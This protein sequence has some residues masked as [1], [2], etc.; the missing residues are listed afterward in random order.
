MAR[1]RVIIDEGEEAVR[2]YDEKYRCMIDLTQDDD[3]D[4]LSLSVQQ[5]PRGHHRA[6]TQRNAPLGS[7]HRSVPVYRI[8]GVRFRV[9]DFVELAQ[10]LGEWQ[11]RFVEVKQIWLNAPGEVLLRGLPYAR[12]SDIGGRFKL[13]TN[14]VCQI[15]EIDN[16]DKRP[17]EQQAMVEV[18]PHE[19]T[20][21]RDFHKT[22]TDYHSARNCRFGNDPFWLRLGKSDAAVRRR[23]DHGP[24]TCRWK[25]RLEYHDARFRRADKAFGTTI[26]HLTESEIDDPLY[27]TCDEQ[28]RR[29]WLKRDPASA[30]RPSEP[31]TCTFGDAFCGCGGASSGAR[32]AGLV[33]RFHPVPVAPLTSS[34]TFS[35]CN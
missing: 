13:G 15:I 21:I 30:G 6:S 29:N 26:S 2:A 32:M 24:L 17:D 18:R 33:V 19:I 34:L 16:D 23:Q 28:R 3:D 20:T 4:G 5:Q 11:V 12:N 7:T 31:W 9:Q 25:M 35:L 14:E 10:P 1:S 22:N 27:R 8:E